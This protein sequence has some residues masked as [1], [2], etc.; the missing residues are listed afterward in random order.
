[1]LSLFYVTLRCSI[2]KNL[3]KIKLLLPLLFPETCY[4]WYRL[5]VYSKNYFSGYIFGQTN[6]YRGYIFVTIYLIVNTCKSFC[7]LGFK[8]KLCWRDGTWKVIFFFHSFCRNASVLKFTNFISFLHQIAK[9]KIMQCCS[10]I[11]G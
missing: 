9:I 5:R 1:M 11:Y 6:S 10:Y 8:R 2:V 4:F 7:I 3:W